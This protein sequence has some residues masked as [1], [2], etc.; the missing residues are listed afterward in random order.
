MGERKRKYAKLG[1]NEE[2]ITNALRTS[3][4]LEQ[5]RVQP[6]SRDGV[7]GYAIEVTRE[8]FGEEYSYH[9]WISMQAFKLEPWPVDQR[10]MID[11]AFVAA[12]QDVIKEKGN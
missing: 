3:D 10:H 4:P 11:R 5:I 9:G 1:Y 7:A 2:I 12:L 6:Y 8:I